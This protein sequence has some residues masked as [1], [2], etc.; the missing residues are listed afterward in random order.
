MGKPVPEKG[1][2]ANRKHST[3]WTSGG[4]ANCMSRSDIL[5]IPL[6]G[7][8]EF[9]HHPTI[10]HWMPGNNI[11]ETGGEKYAHPNIWPK[12]DKLLRVPK[13]A[14]L[15]SLPNWS[16]MWKK[17]V[18]YA[19]RDVIGQ[20]FTA[21]FLFGNY[22]YIEQWDTIESASLLMSGEYSASDPR[23]TNG[24]RFDNGINAGSTITAGSTNFQNANSSD[25]PP[26]P[27]TPDMNVDSGVGDYSGSRF[28]QVIGHI[29]N[30]VPTLHAATMAAGRQASETLASQGIYLIVPQWMPEQLAQ[31]RNGYL[32]ETGER[33]NSGHGTDCNL[34]DVV[35]CYHH[36]PE[37]WGPGY[38]NVN[39]P[40][41]TL[42]FQQPTVP[43]LLNID[44]G[45]GTNCLHMYVGM[46]MHRYFPDNTP[47]AA[48]A[49]PLM[50]EGNYI[51]PLLSGN[52]LGAILPY[53]AG[54]RAI[55]RDYGFDYGY[56]PGVAAIY[57]K[58][59]AIVGAAAASFKQNFYKFR[60]MNTTLN[61]Y[62]GNLFD[63]E[64]KLSEIWNDQ[65]HDCHATQFYFG[66]KFS[67]YQKMFSDEDHWYADCSGDPGNPAHLKFADSISN[68]PDSPS[69]RAA[70]KTFLPP[71]VSRIEEYYNGIKKGTL[72]YYN[73]AVQQTGLSDYG[74]SAGGPAD[75][76]DSDSIIEYVQQYFKDNP[77]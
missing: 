33:Y 25:H 13:V 31:I 46:P 39:D 71:I 56:K 1:L 21:P 18:L 55:W 63:F 41:N 7:D 28:H 61:T 15:S 23:W 3:P 12:K 42:A 5:Q 35:D 11:G 47:W 24:S 76:T 4:P 22:Y 6:Q 10:T 74:V 29:T 45:F 44:P 16:L 62:P 73:Y 59:Q 37:P 34:T 2:H 75:P 72:D 26:P 67:D 17:D 69:L 38:P 68:F 19:P 58:Y 14:I 66:Y 30:N 54:R 64:W 70:V 49:Y 57:N 53:F 9:K 77:S 60:G 48:Q 50:P 8:G 40:R 43:W 27:L 51:G 52:Y 20:M 32:T 36:W 65:K